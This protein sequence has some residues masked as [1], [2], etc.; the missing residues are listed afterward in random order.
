M[1]KIL[2]KFVLPI[3][4]TLFVVAPA[5]AQA[6]A[7]VTPADLLNDPVFAQATSGKKL[8]M[9][10]QMIAEKKISTGTS[11]MTYYAARL[12]WDEIVKAGG[13]KAQIDRYAALVL[14]AP[15]LN[16]LYDLENTLLLN[17]LADDPEASKADSKTRCKLVHQLI[18][19]NKI[20]WPG[21]ASTIHGLLVQHLSTAPEY[22]GKSTEERVKYIRSMEAEGFVGNIT[23]APFLRMLPLPEVSKKATPEE[24]KA[25]VNQI[26]PALG[27]FGESTLKDAYYDMLP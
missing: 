16:A 23:T 15:K 6:P 26:K 25:F 2:S 4:M 3:V 5:N 21:G 24:K 11:K 19:A 20:S 18:T 14:A 10:S 9:I 12:Y 22:V 13:P 8:E 7:T 17:Y 1:K 27:F